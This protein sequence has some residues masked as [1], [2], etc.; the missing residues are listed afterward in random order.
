MALFSNLGINLRD[1]LCGAPTYA[2]A[3]S[4][5]FLDLVNPAEAGLNWILTPVPV[6]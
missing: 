5:D 6:T 1:C 2:S 4:L 3:Q